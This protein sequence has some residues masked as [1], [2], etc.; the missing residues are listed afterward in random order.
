MV[1]DEKHDGNGESSK[2][3]MRDMKLPLKPDITDLIGQRL[4]QF[5]EGVVDQPVPDRFL[6][7][8]DELDRASTT[9]KPK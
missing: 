7:L 9:K 4:R 1:E 3:K 5:Y 8:L 6:Q 2:K